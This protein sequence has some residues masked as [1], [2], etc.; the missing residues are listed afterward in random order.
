V[1]DYAADVDAL[2]DLKIAAGLPVFTFSI[3]AERE[4][5][6]F[7]TGVTGFLGAFILTSLLQP[8]PQSQVICHVR[9]RDELDTPH[10]IQINGA[11]HHFYW[12][13][14]WLETHIRVLAEIRPSRAWVCPSLCGTTCAHK[15]T[16]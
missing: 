8:Y 12:K 2:D 7:L 6:F 3:E 16:L 14:E 13:K 4:N 1:F 11:Q 5:V 10:R 9:A 15:W